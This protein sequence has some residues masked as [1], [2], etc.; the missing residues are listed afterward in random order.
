MNHAAPSPER[1]S[2]T[3]FR[4]QLVLLGSFVLFGTAIVMWVVRLIYISWVWKDVF[5]ASIA[6]A[7][8]AVPIFIFILAVFNYV[9]W[10]ILLGRQDKSDHPS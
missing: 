7:F 1:Q 2:P 9:F 3:V 10:G 4:L 6:I 5:S 8:V